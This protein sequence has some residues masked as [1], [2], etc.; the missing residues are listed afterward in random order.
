MNFIAS[1]MKAVLWFFFFLKKTLFIYVNH[2]K[3]Y[4]KSN[5][6]K[7]QGR[8]IFINEIVAKKRTRYG[9]LVVY[10]PVNCLLVYV[11]AKLSSLI[12]LWL[13]NQNVFVRLLILVVK[14]QCKCIAELFV[15]SKS[16]QNEISQFCEYV[17][18]WILYR[19]NDVIY[20]H[21]F[22]I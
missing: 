7:L 10:V 11:P 20:W 16:R 9:E 1:D 13:I 4:T 14:G 8:F 2:M 18:Y 6:I 5:I 21:I 3:K 17:L 19:E 15:I 12:E 22:C